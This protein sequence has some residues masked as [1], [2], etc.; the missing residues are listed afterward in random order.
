M[1]EQYPQMDGLC[2]TACA[3]AA[4]VRQFAE[5]RG[6]PFD[7][8]MTELEER[9]EQVRWKVMPA[10]PQRRENCGTLDVP[11][12]ECRVLRLVQGIASCYGMTA[13]QYMESAYVD[14]FFSGVADGRSGTAVAI[15]AAVEAAEEAGA[16]PT[17][18]KEL[19]G[20][21]SGRKF[22][23]ELPESWKRLRLPA[24]T[25]NTRH[26]V[27]AFGLTLGVV[28]LIVAAA[29]IYR[30]GYNGA[31]AEKG[32]YDAGFAAAMAERGTYQEG[33]DAAIAEKGTYDDGYTA[34]FAKGKTEGYEEGYAAGHEDGSSEG[35]DAGYDSGTSDAAQSAA[36]AEKNTRVW[37][38]KRLGSRYHSSPDCPLVI[39]PK[40]MTRQEAEDE[41]Y[42][43]CDWCW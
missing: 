3:Y 32:T 28:L 41:G 11:A 2:D 9:L 21:G 37:V 13:Q 10:G 27:L 43:S 29:G 31:I 17:D 23:W 7:D 5:Q 8:A 26:F 42:T 6:V 34:G 12:E 40:E 36:E 19:P 14:D 30:W 33:Y 24:M 15:S 4:R 35:Y 16:Q 20:G 1:A 38:S 25:K 39:K 18:D 22:L